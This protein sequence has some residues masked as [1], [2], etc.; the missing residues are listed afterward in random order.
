MQKL[1]ADAADT[2][3]LQ[4]ESGT[5]FYNLGQ[6]TVPSIISAAIRLVVVAAAIIFF[7]WSS[8]E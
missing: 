2:I 5:T 4:P 6:L 8:A 7:F 1:L 3:K